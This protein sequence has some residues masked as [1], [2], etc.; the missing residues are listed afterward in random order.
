METANQRFETTQ[1]PFFRGRNV[2]AD[3]KTWRCGHYV[4]SKRRLPTTR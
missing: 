1:C 3:F 2:L 4:A